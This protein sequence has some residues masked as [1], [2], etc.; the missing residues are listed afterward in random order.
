MVL[1]PR[2]ELMYF[3]PKFFEAVHM[4]VDQTDAADQTALCG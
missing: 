4:F 3:M 2:G 1:V